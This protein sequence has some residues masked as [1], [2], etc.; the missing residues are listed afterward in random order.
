[1]NSSAAVKSH[2]NAFGIQIS[3]LAINYLQ[4]ENALYVEEKAYNSTCFLID[5]ES[6]SYIQQMM[7]SQGCF[8]EIYTV[9]L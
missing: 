6:V 8:I 7:Q 2:V 1:M 4:K 9:A 3:K 5:R